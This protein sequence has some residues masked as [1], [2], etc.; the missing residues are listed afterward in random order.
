MQGSHIGTDSEI[1]ATVQLHVV[2]IHTHNR[3]VEEYEEEEEVN[4]QCK[5]NLVTCIELW[6]LSNQHFRIHTDFFPSKMSKATLINNCKRLTRFT[7]NR[8]INCMVILYMETKIKYRNQS[9]TYKS[10]FAEWMNLH[11]HLCICENRKR[12]AHRF[13][14]PVHKH[15]YISYS[16]IFLLSALPNKCSLSTLVVLGVLCMQIE[17]CI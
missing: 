12:I 16:R 13:L 7:V 10:Y 8:S 17:K 14:I 15:M 11:H 1:S 5:H 2:A 9:P 4:K 6:L 3:K